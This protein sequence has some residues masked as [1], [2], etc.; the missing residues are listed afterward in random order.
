MKSF[1]F[2]A[3]VFAAMGV[4]VVRASEPFVY[5]EK[6]VPKVAPEPPMIREAE[7]A[8]T[9]AQDPKWHASHNPRVVA[10]LKHH[11]RAK[12]KHMSPRHQAK[13]V[14]ANLVDPKPKRVHRERDEGVRA[15]VIVRHP[16][17]RPKDP[18]PV[19]VRAHVI[20]DEPKR[21]HHH[22]RDLVSANAHIKWDDHHKEHL[23]AE[24]EAREG[25]VANAHIDAPARHHHRRHHKRADAV[26]ANA[27]ITPEPSGREHRLARHLR[28]LKKAAKRE[29]DLVTPIA[30]ITRDD[31]PRRHHRH[32]KREA[33]IVSADVKLFS[34]G[35]DG[36]PAKPHHR[37]HHHK[38]HEPEL[39]SADVKV[40]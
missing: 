22:K 3:I 31:E 36:A 35:N 15:H 37:H 4:A 6:R 21:H 29:A 30:H 25:V 33:E 2:A 9:P 18:E 20:P 17:R 8:P 24:R 13:F 11:K 27:H 39:V 19:T 14:A 1:V 26:V 10:N 23:R 32:H 38:H 28:H 7:L 40:V 34:K 12:N 5:G 16:E